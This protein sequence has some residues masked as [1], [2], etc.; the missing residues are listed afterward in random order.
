MSDTYT[1]TTTTSLGS[2][3]TNSLAGVI[4]G[5]VLFVGAFPVI[6]WNEGRAIKR[7]K[8]LNEG[9][10][11]CVTIDAEKPEGDLEGRLVHL[12]GKVKTAELLNDSVFGQSVSNSLRF[13]RKVMMY[14]WVE[15]EESKTVKKTGGSTETTTTYTYT[16]EWVDHPVNS[17]SFEKPEGHENPLEWPVRG[18]EWQVAE[19][20]LGVF[21]LSEKQ[22]SRAGSE[23]PFQP[24]VTNNMPLPVGL[25][26]TYVRTA[27]GFYRPAA[28]GSSM[29]APKVGDLMVKFGVVPVC[30][31]SL[32]GAKSGSYIRSFPTKYG[33]IL[34]Q[35]NGDLSK[36]EIFAAAHRDNTILTWLVRLGALLMFF[37]GLRLLVKPLTV[38]SD[39]LPFFGNIMEYVTGAAAFLA[40]LILTIITVA[41]AWLTVRPVLG[42]ALLVAAVLLIVWAKK[43]SAKKKA[44]V[45]SE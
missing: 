44:Q 26:S 1:K 6:F 10:S 11:V 38:L 42:I 14:Q 33:D 22:I 2:R 24:F 12:S 15:H 30:M 39:I 13:S 27:E 7:T 28:A 29:G 3:L 21:E 4:V 18:E 9:E 37:I 8:A 23:K 40:A 41:L 17:S 5:L 43:S 25:D 16:K 45:K 32:A 35:Y 36:S 20:S 31:I 19:A 34:L